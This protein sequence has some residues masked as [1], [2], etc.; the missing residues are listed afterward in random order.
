MP[1]NYNPTRRLIFSSLGMIISVI[2][3]A[4]AIFSYFPIWIA[5]EDA[6]I[7]SGFSLLLLAIALV[8]FYRHLRAALRSPSAPL[9]WFVFFITFFLLARIAD[10]MT[11]ISFVGF[12]SNLIGSIFFRIARKYGKEISNEGRT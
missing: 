11:I 3:V 10:E 5:R 6:S 4:V 12:S 9:M 7:L 8:P 1:S 2:P